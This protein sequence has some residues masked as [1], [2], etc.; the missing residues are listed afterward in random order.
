MKEK[1]NG[2]EVEVLRDENETEIDEE[3]KEEEEVHEAHE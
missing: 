1:E 2:G 3:G